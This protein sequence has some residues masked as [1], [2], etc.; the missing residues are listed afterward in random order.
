MEHETLEAL[1]IHLLHLLL[2]VGRAE[3]GGDE[4]LRLAARED[5]RPMDPR[6]DAHFRPDV[7]HLIERAPV[8]A[9]SPVEHLVA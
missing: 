8:E 7:A 1:A 3:R 5:G 9:V 6:Q 2:I 4:R